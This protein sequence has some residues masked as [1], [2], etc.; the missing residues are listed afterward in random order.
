MAPTPREVQSALS[1]WV[2]E[3]SR[4]HTVVGLFPRGLE[5]E[6]SPFLPLHLEDTSKTTPAC[7]FGRTEQDSKPQ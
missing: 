7:G 5:V 4:S 3:G 1:G 2:L 6:K